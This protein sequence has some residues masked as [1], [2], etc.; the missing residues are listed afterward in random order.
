LDEIAYLDGIDDVDTTIKV[1]MNPGGTVKTGMVPP[2]FNAR[3][4][5][6]PFSIR[7]V[8]NLKLCVYY[9]KHVERVQRKSIANSI[10][11]VLVCSYRDQ[12]HHDVSFKKTAEDPVINEKD[13]HRTLETIK[14][15]ITSQYGGA[16]DTLDYV[17]WPDIEVNPET[18]DHAE[19]YES[20]DQEM[21]A[22]APHTG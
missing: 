11:L 12:Q 1:V 4:N 7:A 5:G 10:N 15:Y 9:L 2:A 6:I 16:G 22:R 18:E 3:K 20:G 19:G 14:E 13:W 21:T 8:D 17:V